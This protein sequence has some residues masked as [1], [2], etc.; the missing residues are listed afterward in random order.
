MNLKK[1]LLFYSS[2]FVTETVIF[3]EQIMECSSGG[4]LE[5]NLAPS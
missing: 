4:L 1:P 3:S 5:I 2:A